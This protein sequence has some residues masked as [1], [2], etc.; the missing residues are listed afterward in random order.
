MEPWEGGGRGARKRQLSHDTKRLRHCGTGTRRQACKEY[1]GGI[2]IAGRRK[3]ERREVGGFEEV[4]GAER[5]RAVL[6]KLSGGGQVPLDEARAGGRAIVVADLKHEREIAIVLGCV[7]R[8]R[9]E[10]GLVSVARTID[11]GDNRARFVEQVVAEDIRER[12]IVVVGE[13]VRRD[14]E[15]GGG[16]RL[17]GIARVGGR[18]EGARATRGLGRGTFARP[19]TS[20]CGTRRR[21]SSGRSGAC[22]RCVC[23]K[24]VGK[25]RGRGRRAC[26]ER[27]THVSDA[28]IENRRP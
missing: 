14:S 4:R 28:Q 8:C 19:I 3:R 12:E 5:E 20:C 24:H 16:G 22:L 2:P 7:R 9:G 23:R 21:S 1:G 10:R 13:R 11:A 17:I 26:V 27:R 18:R 6:G 25:R 15:R